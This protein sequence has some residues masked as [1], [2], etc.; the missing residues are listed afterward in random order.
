MVTDIPKVTGIWFVEFVSPC[1]EIF[2]V[3]PESQKL[4]LSPVSTRAFI[5]YR[6][7][8]VGKVTFGTALV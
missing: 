7:Y 3:L 6:F 1:D 8:R 5:L 2:S 4:T